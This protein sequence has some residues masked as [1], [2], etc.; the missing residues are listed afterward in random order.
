MPD[1]VILNIRSVPTTTRERMLRA[2]SARRM[3]L[4][5]YLTAL[6]ALHD[7]MRALADAPTDDD[8]WRR[9]RKELEALGLQTITA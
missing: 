3:N 7:A 2:A 5:E 9:V 6:V 1:L 4:A 8:R